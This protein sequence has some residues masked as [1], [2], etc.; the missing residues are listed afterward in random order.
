MKK[1]LGLCCTIWCWQLGAQITDTLKLLESDSLHPM[2]H[3]IISEG[4]LGITDRKS[5]L[6]IIR[7]GQE[8]WRAN[9]ALN[10]AQS[11]SFLPGVNAQNTGVGIARPVIRGMSGQRIVVAENGIKQEGQQWGSDHG[12]ELDMFTVDGI[13]IVK[14]A[15]GLV[16]GS[17][18]I[19]GAIKILPP[20]WCVGKRELRFLTQGSNNNQER[21]YSGAYQQKWKWKKSGYVSRF[22][23]VVSKKKSSDYRLPAD[24]FTYLNRTL[25]LVNGIL[26]NTATNEQ[27]AMGLW[28]IIHAQRH[29]Q[30]LSI[31]YR[32]FK[33]NSG[34]FP[35]F[36]G[37]PT[38]SSVSSDGNPSNIGWPSAQVDHH[39][40]TAFSTWKLRNGTHDLAMSYQ[41]NH[42][43]EMSKPHQGAYIVADDSGKAL[44]LNL[45]DIQLRYACRNLTWWSGSGEWGISAE[46]QWNKRGGFEFLLPDFH[47]EMSGVWGVWSRSTSNDEGQWNLGARWDYVSYQTPGFGQAIELNGDSYLWQPVSKSAR[48]FRGLAGSIGQSI[49]SSKEWHWKWHFGRT[50][51]FPQASELFINGVHHGTFRHEMGDSN[52]SSEKGWQ[53]DGMMIKS[54]EEWVL[55][56]SPFVQYYSSY[57]YLSPQARFSTL[58]DGGQVYAYV[59]HPVWMGGGE[60]NLD[61]HVLPSLHSDCSI[62]YIANYNAKTELPLPF[63]PPFQVKWG[64]TY[65]GKWSQN[66]EWNCQ[67]QVRYAAAQ[68][69]VDRNEKSTPDY[70]L[71]HG[72]FS[73]EYHKPDESWYCIWSINGRN[74]T[75]V[76]YLNN[77]SNYRALQLPE[78]GRWIQMGLELRWNE[79]KNKL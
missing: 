53:W 59:Q 48:Q 11:L 26:N 5:S 25:P 51:R 49:S 12:L 8:D 57:I 22:V 66:W 38:L 3:L 27:A 19:G 54:N 37:I 58:P 28:E 6:D 15:A 14:G 42:R 72:G 30:H 73:V 55:K 31:Q 10:F 68:K 78:Q 71:V 40:W 7:I 61:I 64:N 62:E 74:L 41:S 9:R 24:E 17:D 36:V 46:K 67:F 4:W 56:C 29:L 70:A 2:E 32:W 76:K 77:L 52:L 50:Y 35:G 21:G 44:Q 33:Q 79:I 16:Y 47:K 45:S 43:N 75:D 20:K 63:T 34:L 13:E 65:Q 69:R 60:C 18:A 23:A 39:K 1:I